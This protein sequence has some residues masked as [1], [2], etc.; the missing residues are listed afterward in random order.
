VT[1]Y[2][3]FN[4]ELSNAKTYDKDGFMSRQ[5]RLFD[6]FKNRL[7]KTAYWMLKKSWRFTKPTT[8]G[9]RAIVIN[10]QNE[11]LLV[12]HTYT[13]SWYLPGG[14]VNKGEH[15]LPSL[16]REMFEELNLTIGSPPQLLSVYMN[17]YEY[18]NDCVSVFI[19]KDFD[20]KPSVNNEICDWSFF[21]FETLP[22]TISPGSKKRIE[23]YFGKKP[24]SHIW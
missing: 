5:Q 13:D 7:L 21:N 2:N 9:V 24:I 14:G 23:E 3:P 18:K 6:R 20:M 17:F 8:L 19:I 10:D 22:K 1:Y 4:A 12:R 15:L 16:K 11:F